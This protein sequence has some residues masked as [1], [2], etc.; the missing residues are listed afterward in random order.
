MAMEM[1]LVFVYGTLKFNQPNH[2]WLTDHA[3]GV[4]FFI[5]NGKT[6]D[7]YPFVIATRYNIP[8]LVERPS[9]GNVI[10]GE[11]YEVNEKMLGKLDE[12]EQHPVY[13]LRKQINISAADAE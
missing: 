5:S 12:L 2:H 4:S 1:F 11:V 3:N 7:K 8:F 9:V 13:Y 10:N 6:S